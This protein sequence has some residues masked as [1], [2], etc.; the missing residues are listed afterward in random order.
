[1]ISPHLHLVDA[2]GR[3]LSPAIQAAVEQAHRWVLREF[4]SVDP[5]MIADWAEAIG[6]SM[7]DRGNL[8]ASPN[9]YAYA[10]LKGKVRDWL[11][12]KTAQEESAG[13]GPDLERI[14]GTA[15]S[16]QGAVDRKLLFEQLR[17]NLNE[18]DR[19]ILVLLLQDETSP[20]AVAKALGVTYSAAAKAIQRVK[21]RVAEAL[22]GSRTSRDHNMAQS[23]RI[24]E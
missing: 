13:I 4:R 16:F 1:M 15:S 19:S 11:R 5:A 9:R 17:A 23:S 24:K 20:A 7:Q 22:N 21:E 12:T 8:I 2:Q 6:A 3:S 14:G 10:A 18:R